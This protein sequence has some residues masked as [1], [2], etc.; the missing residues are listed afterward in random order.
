MINRA[1][2][3]EAFLG[4]ACYHLVP[5]IEP[6]DLAALSAARGEGPIFASAKIDASD[7]ETAKTLAQLGFRTI[8]T[9]IL[10]RVRLD[11]ASRSAG[12]VLITSAWIL[13]RRMFASTLRNSGAASG[14]IL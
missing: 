11:G 14:K 12:D 9:Q 5:P 10:L 4:V 3:D 7:D 13:N 6:S 8:C 2:F 1:R